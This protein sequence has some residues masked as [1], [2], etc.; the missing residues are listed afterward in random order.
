MGHRNLDVL[1]AARRAADAVN[2]L[3]DRKRA[4]RLVCVSQLRDSVQA[5][6]ANISEGFG[7][8][9]GPDRNHRLVIA[10]GETEETIQH[11]GT[12]FRTGRISAKEHWPIHNLLNVIVKMLNSMLA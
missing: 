3:I 12:N 8:N 7:R 4:R 5:I 6:S 11:L 10:R 1:D 9:P 2:E